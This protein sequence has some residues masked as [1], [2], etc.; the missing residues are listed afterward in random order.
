MTSVDRLWRYPVKSMRDEDVPEFQLVRRG[1]PVPIERV[2]PRRG[3][4]AATINV[5][6]AET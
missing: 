5:K 3:V 1:D 2:Q 4:L 6:A